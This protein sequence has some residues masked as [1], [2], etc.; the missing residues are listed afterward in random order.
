MRLPDPN[1]ILLPLARDGRLADPRALDQVATR[2][3]R[4]TD[5][6]VFCPGWHDKPQEVREAAARFFSLL[7]RALMPLGEHAARL[8]VAVSWPSRSFPVPGPTAAPDL[9]R[10]LDDITRTEPG[11]LARWLVT[12]AETEVP[13][14]PEEELE[15]D[16][17]LR[18][19]REPRLRGRGLSPAHALSF[20]I[21]KRRAGQVGERLGREHLGPVFASHPG[22]R[23]H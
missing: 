7:D 17:V 11:R 22:L 3:P 16:G 20:W 18:G 2:L 9:V 1:P 4:A 14:G 6:V 10:G 13:R 8:G 23:L 21:T 12:M 15:L 19:L 5:C